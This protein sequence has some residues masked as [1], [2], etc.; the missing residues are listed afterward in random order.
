MNRRLAVFAPVAALALLQ[1]S[2]CERAVPPPPPGGVYRSHTAGASFEQSVDIAGK[3]G[4][5]VALFSLFDI[6]R[7][8]EQP[9]RIYI[10][11]G[12]RGI[13]ASDND[14]VSWQ[15]IPTPLANTY[16]VTVLGSGIL[17]ASGSDGAGQGFVIRSLDEGKSW[18]TVLTVPVPVDESGFK[19][20][21]GAPTVPSVVLSLE[22]DPF[23]SERVWAGSSLGTLFAGEQ[24]AKVWRNF[25]TLKPDAFNPQLQPTNVTIK[26]IV[27]SPH[28]PNE[29]LVITRPGQMILVNGDDQK[30]IKVPQYL[31]TPP[32][33]GTSSGNK[34]IQD[35]VFIPGFP[36]ALL[37]GVE[38]GAVVTRD[39]GQTWVALPVP[40]EP[41]Q[42]F[43]SI[44]VA[45]SPTNTNRLLVAVNDVIYRSEDG[46]NT[47]NTFA[48]GL[49]AHLV[50]GLSI[51][52]D[53]AARVLIVTSTNQS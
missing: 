19:I 48:L 41:N 44:V 38:D 28:R 12:G 4:E 36:D 7:S 31:N 30:K 15:I 43:N 17:V 10:A 46:G 20:I 25:Q 21:G 42:K 18:Q 53:N 1:L 26:K 14:G 24:S 16:D 33:V 2:G 45:V 35:A 9:D 51:N 29:M 32:P 50:T 23:N 39:G 6:F 47:W 3:T 34:K 37:V 11:A 27:V 40:I 5:Y 8:P 13:V 22:R 49:P 52:P